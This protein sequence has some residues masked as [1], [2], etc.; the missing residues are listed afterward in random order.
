M[1]RS[2]GTTAAAIFSASSKHPYSFRSRTA[3]GGT[4][5]ST[6]ITKEGKGLSTQSRRACINTPAF[7]LEVM[8]VMEVMEVTAASSRT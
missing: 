4:P 3:S 6:M 2:L 5:L 7:Q 8:E 1:D